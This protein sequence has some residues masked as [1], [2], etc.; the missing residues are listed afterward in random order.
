V[1]PLFKGYDTVVLGDRE[2]CSVRLARWLKLQGQS[3]KQKGLQK[4]IG[5]VKEPG[6]VTP[7]HSHFYIGLYGQAWVQ[8]MADCSEIVDQLLLLSP[9]KRPYYKKGRR[10]M[11]LI[12]SV[13]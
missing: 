1:L 13:F 2:F 9:H 6:R 10:A 5:R 4:Y 7:R 12:G 3:I 11:E 8:F